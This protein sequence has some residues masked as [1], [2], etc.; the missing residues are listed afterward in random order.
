MHMDSHVVSMWTPLWF[1]CGHP[2]GFHL[3]T[4][5]V[6]HEKCKWVCH[7]ES[8]CFWLGNHHL[9]PCEHL[10]G[11]R[12]SVHVVTMLC[13][14]ENHMEV[15]VDTTCFLHGYHVVS[16]IW[17]H[18]VSTWK[19]HDFNVEADVAIHMS[20]QVVFTWK[21]HGVHLETTWCPHIPAM[22]RSI[23]DTTCDLDPCRNHGEFPCGLLLGFLVDTT[24][25][26]CGCYI[27]STLTLVNCYCV[28]KIFE[29][30]KEA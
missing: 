9:K 27:A 3:D 5:M 10:L 25:F 14:H 24:W 22:C 4:N 12:R 7:I 13:P 17:Y 20:N 1:P 18:M 2:C 23:L 28:I 6:S 21:P 8:T 29:I 16:M 19:P 26:T 15:H 30:Q 11:R